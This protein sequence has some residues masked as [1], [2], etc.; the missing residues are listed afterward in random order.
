MTRTQ[1]SFE[2]ETLKRAKR[3]AAQLGISLAEYVRRLVDK[4]LTRGRPSGDPSVI[5]DLGGSG[6]TD[7]A[8]AKQALLGE[9]TAK[10]RR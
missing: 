2:R 4:D 5:F 6:G 1:L 8:S 10:G 9:A 3:R 7:I